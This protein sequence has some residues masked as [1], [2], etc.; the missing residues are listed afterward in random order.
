MAAIEELENQLREAEEER[1]L[2]KEI[3]F[4]DLES[5]RR[6]AIE[7]LDVKLANLEDERNS[8]KEIPDQHLR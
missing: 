7:D 5:E 6:K 1:K 4:D 8:L 3:P 2:A